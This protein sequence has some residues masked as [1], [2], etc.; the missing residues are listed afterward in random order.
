MLQD[1]PEHQD[2]T[3]ETA[4]LSMALA[5][6]QN[7]LSIATRDEVQAEE[8]VGVIR[9]L[10]RRKGFTF[11]LTHSSVGGGIPS[12]ELPTYRDDISDSEVESDSEVAP[13]EH[14]GNSGLP[15]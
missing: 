10:L 8:D 13:A 9:E 2:T 5:A 11:Q 12:D 15:L 14:A 7:D 3:R 1:A 4:S 6:H